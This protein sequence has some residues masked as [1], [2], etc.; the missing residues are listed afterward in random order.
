M[1]PE[2]SLVTIVNKLI[3]VPLARMLRRIATAHDEHQELRHAGFSR[4]RKKI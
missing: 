4:E 3:L 1:I 2:I